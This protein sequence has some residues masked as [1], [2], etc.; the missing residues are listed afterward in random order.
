[1]SAFMA[2]H[3]SGLMP[4]LPQRIVLFTEQR[5]PLSSSIAALS[6]IRGTT[7]EKVHD[8]ET[9]ELLLGDIKI[10]DSSLQYINDLLRDM[11][12]KKLRSSTTQLCNAN[13]P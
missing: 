6:F 12:G 3:H 9:K 11:L 8:Q 13:C 7:Q 1:M 10:L 5:N 4:S 2:Y